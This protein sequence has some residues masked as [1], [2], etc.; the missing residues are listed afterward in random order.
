[1][2]GVLISVD[3]YKIVCRFIV[4]AAHMTPPPPT[5]LP[6]NLSYTSPIRLILFS[7]N[8]SYTDSFNILCSVAWVAP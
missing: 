4:S 6:L 8:P 3:K 2:I 1:M 5:A 7:V